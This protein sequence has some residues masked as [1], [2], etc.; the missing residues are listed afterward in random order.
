MGRLRY[1][2]M[3]E[4]YDLG[5]IFRKKGLSGLL[6]TVF[7]C[8]P[9]PSTDTDFAKMQMK[10]SQIA[11][12]RVEFHEVQKLYFNFWKNHARRI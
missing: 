11:C 7:K 3:P 12:M 1:N 2:E 9:R 8:S 4:D 10:I 6:K 5:K